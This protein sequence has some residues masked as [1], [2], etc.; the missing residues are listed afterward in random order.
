[1]SQPVVNQK[2][3][4]RMEPSIEPSGFTS[5]AQRETVLDKGMLLV[6]TNPDNLNMVE[7]YEK[8]LG[9]LTMDALRLLVH[10]LSDVKVAHV[11]ATAF[12]GGVA[13]LLHRQ[14]PLMNQLGE[15]VN[16][17]TD[18]YILNVSHPAFY[19][20]TKKCH[21]SLQGGAGELNAEEKDHY[22]R[23]LLANFGSGQ[24][25]HYDVVFI[26]DPQPAGLIELYPQHTNKWVWRCHIDTTTP[27]PEVWEFFARFLKQYDLAVWTRDSF[28]H[29]RADFRG[30]R[31]IAPSIDPISLKN[32]MMS[33]DAVEHIL[34]HYGIDPHRPI[35]TQ[36]SRFDPWKQPLEVIQVYKE[37]KAEFPGLQLILAG[38][39]ATDDPEGLLYWERSLRKAGEDPDLFI[40]NNYHGIGNLEINAFQ[41]AAQVLLQYSSK[42]GFGLTVSEG[43]WK[44][45]PVIGGR[46]GGIQDQIEE[47]QSGFLVS[48]LDEVKAAARQLLNNP[49]QRQEM[50][51]LAHQR[52]AEHFLITREVADYLKVIR[53]LKSKAHTPSQ[54]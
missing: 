29:D 5:L 14:I 34:L 7:L 40:L 19:D 10:D 39:M 13:E 45:Q 2:P 4:A 21:N 24:L 12:G 37:L 31:I 54:S 16:F 36:V 28:V 25:T 30:L 47:G 26:H 6:Q 51:E 8:E 20:M 48:T 49:A 18:W 52:V 32:S 17:K 41:R 42:E 23:T 15:P 1:V 35:M 38:S 43:M 46:V 53:D 22:Y 9:S 50:G 44:Y 33:P 27:N 11:N 3:I